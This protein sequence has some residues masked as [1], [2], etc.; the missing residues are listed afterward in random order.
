[1]RLDNALRLAAAAWEEAGVGAPHL[2]LRFLRL[3]YANRTSRGRTIRRVPGERVLPFVDQASAGDVVVPVYNNYGDT[4]ALLDD[5]TRDEDFK[6][7][8]VIVHDA[9]TDARLAPLLAGF[10]ARDPRAH[11]IGNDNNLGFVKS[12][13]LGFAATRGNVV[14][15]NTDIGLPKGAISRLL[16]RLKSNPSAA[17]ATPFSNSAYGVGVPDLVYPNASPFGA[18]VAAI[19]FAF[20]NLRPAADVELATGVGFCLAISRSALDRIG[21]F[22]VAFGAGYGEETDFCQRARKAG[23]RHLLASD[24]YVEHK[25]GKSF[26]GNWQDKSRRGLLKVLNRHPDYVARAAA[27]LIAGEP[28]AIAFAALVTLAENLSGEP[29][30]ISETRATGIEDGR[31]RVAVMANGN[32]VRVALTYAEESYEFPF[33]ERRLFDAALALRPMRDRPGIS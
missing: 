32:T 2:L 13:N 23:F 16:R 12:C 25:G 30:L 28:R 1:M 5:L 10:V 11:L 15:L 33:S 3:A 24:V 27:H 26:G 8:I 19:D 6:G 14:I 21:G 7:R 4:R 9:S 31:P 22:D 29:A 17:T 20:R 18:D